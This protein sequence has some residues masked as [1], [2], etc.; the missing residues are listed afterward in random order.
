[1]PDSNPCISYHALNGF[2][3]PSTLKIAGKLFGKEVIVLIDSG[4]TNNFIQTRWA[5]HLSLAVQPFSHLKVTIGNGE[6][7]TC[8]G[9]YLQVPLHLGDMVFQVDL[10]LLPVFGADLVLGV[11]WLARLG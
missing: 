3:V 6:I 1:M 7:L 9:E 8:R 10:L 5:H 11:H 4:S 2:P